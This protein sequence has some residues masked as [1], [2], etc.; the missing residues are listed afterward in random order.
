MQVPQYKREVRLSQAGNGVDDR[1]SR[2]W[3]HPLSKAVASRSKLEIARV[4][5]GRHVDG[6]TS[7]WLDV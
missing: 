1:A 7:L 6:S 3:F 4:V 2:Q 5:K